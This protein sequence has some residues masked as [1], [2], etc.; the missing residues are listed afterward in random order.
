ME[1][2]NLHVA[3]VAILAGLLMG[4]AIGLFFV[5]H[6]WLGGYGSWRRRMLRLAH[7]SL[8][9]TGLLNLAFAL[10]IGPLGLQGGGVRIPSLLLVVGAATMPAVCCLSAW[11]ESFRHLFLVPVASLVGAAAVVVVRGWVP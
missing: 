6:D 4:T 5:R 10:S 11:R 3:W 7:V 2:L 9:G 8:V 1:R